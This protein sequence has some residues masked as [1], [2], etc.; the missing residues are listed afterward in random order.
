MQSE[1][2]FAGKIANNIAK[3]K[4]S[5]TTVTALVV[6]VALMI[7]LSS[8]VVGVVNVW[9]DNFF[10]TSG[11]DTIVGTEDD[12]IR[13]GS[14]DD[15]IELAG[16]TDEEGVEGLDKAYGGEGKDDIRADSEEGF[17]LIY[18]GRDDDTIV[19]GGGVGKIHG[20][21]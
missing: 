18:G 11:P 4:N 12:D 17:S 8:P 3:T 16:V 20:G 7:L 10:G 19:G 15:R 13:G 5:K 2:P 14:G 21:R 1:P 9:A 6:T